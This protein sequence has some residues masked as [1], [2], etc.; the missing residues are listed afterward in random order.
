MGLGREFARRFAADGHNVILV[1]R[2][3]DKLRALA[4]ELTA[5]GRCEAEVVTMDL[6]DPDAPRALFEELQSRGREIDFL[7]NN[8]GFGS[9][10]PFVKQPLERE[11]EMVQLNI[12]ALMS[13]CHLF[14][15]PMLQRKSGRILNVA[16]TAGFQ[17]GPFMA[18]Y[19]ASKAFVLHF[20]E[21]LAHECKGTGVTITAHCPGA[22]LTQFGKTAGS[23][24]SKLFK[25]AGAE[26][27]GVAAD[28]YRAMMAGKIVAVSGFSNQL[29][30]FLLRFSPRAVIRRITA[31]LNRT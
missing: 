16:S 23:D 14:A 19:Y 15:P 30:T 12:C 13:L 6:C 24:K 4:D 27:S 20:S 11:L 22:T 7:V 29:G 5:Q 9:N 2:S 31:W 25:V 21:A 28:G 17:P 1:A 26:A 10:G 8:A 18:T 3:E